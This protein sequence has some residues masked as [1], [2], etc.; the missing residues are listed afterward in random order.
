[1]DK[2]GGIISGNEEDETGSLV[3]LTP[4]PT[5]T[6]ARGEGKRRV[7]QGPREPMVFIVKAGLRGVLL[8]LGRGKREVPLGYIPLS[9]LEGH[10]VE[11]AYEVV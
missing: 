4:L 7:P 9:V 1:M 3:G 10:S 8:G 2:Y 5:R 11:A 6:G